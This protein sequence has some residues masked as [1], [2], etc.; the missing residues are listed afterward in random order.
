MAQAQ[1]NLL[2][3]LHSD[4]NTPSHHGDVMQE[5]RLSKA[6][7]DMVGGE[8]GEVE[9]HGESDINIYNTRLLFWTKQIPISHFLESH[10]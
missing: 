10:H 6:N 1:E 2:K 8:E 3:P 4:A 7:K 5:C 9:M